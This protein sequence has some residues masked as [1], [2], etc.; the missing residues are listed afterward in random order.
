MS[1]TGVKQQPQKQTRHSLVKQV[2]S[3]AQ[4]KLR[5]KR[6]SSPGVWFGLGMMGMIGWSVAVPTFLGVILGIW[7]DNNFDN[8]RSWTLALLLAGLAIG[9]FTAWGWV[10]KEHRAIGDDSAHPKNNAISEEED[11]P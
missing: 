5:A 7:I 3:K 11:K 6:R 8:Q 4:L 1:K 9:C 10:S 2:E